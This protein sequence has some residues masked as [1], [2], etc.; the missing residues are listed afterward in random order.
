MKILPSLLSVSLVFGYPVWA[1]EPLNIGIY[2][3]LTGNFASEGRSVLHGIKIAHQVRPQVLGRPVALKVADTRSDL[4]SAADAVFT[5][6]EKERVK[7]IIGELNSGPTIAGSF[8]AERRGIP[9]V[10]PTAT[11]P[12]VTR[13]ARCVFQMCAIDEDQGRL[14]ASLVLSRFH[15]GTAALVCDVSQESSVGM[16]AAFKEAFKLAG[17]RI[18]VETRCK[19]GD[20]DFFAQIGRIKAAQPDV[21]YA[22]ISSTE[23]ALFARQARLMRLCAPIV[24]GHKVHDPGLMAFGGAAVEKL[25]F[26]APLHEGLLRTERG[27]RFLA[28]YRSQMGR[29]PQAGQVLAAEA[30]FVLLD[31]IERAGSAI[32]T[33][34]RDALASRGNF[35]RV[36]GTMGVRSNG[37]ARKPACVRQ[38]KHGRFVRVSE[39][40]HTSP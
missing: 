1:L 4:A 38:V 29:K 36:L 8:H 15:A 17:G 7:A 22:P 2:L 26:T 28:A 14:A 6:I 3:P 19:A 40:G 33:K 20:R 34:I 37:N 11:S 10:T 39:T 16:I 18:V 30:Y 31:A 24:A 5:L 21:I 9:M 32:P 27:K 13:G 35:E 12:M 25:L 23:C